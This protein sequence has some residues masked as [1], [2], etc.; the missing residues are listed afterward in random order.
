MITGTCHCGAIQWSF[1]R[2]PRIGH[3]RCRRS[4]SL[5][6]YDDEIEAIRTSGPTTVYIRGADI[7]LHCC[8]V[9]GLSSASMPAPRPSPL[10]RL[11]ALWAG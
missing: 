9:C 4:A 8:A 10:M 5:W 2:V 1:A 7:E 11:L 6:A 3:R